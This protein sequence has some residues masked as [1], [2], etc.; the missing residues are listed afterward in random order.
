VRTL[1]VVGIGSGDPRQLTGQA[2]D[3]LARAD[4]VLVLE[5]EKGDDGDALAAFRRALLG[6]GMAGDHRVVVR[7]DPERDR[8]AG[9]YLGSVAAWHEARVDVY[10]QVLREELAEGEVAA[11]LVWGDPSLYDST[12]RIVDRLHERDTV[13]FEHEVVPGI[14]SVQALCAAHR[15]PLNRVGGSV[16]VTT[17]R[18]LAEGK[19]EGVDDVVVL[20]DGSCAFQEVDAERAHIWWG[21]YLGMPEQV[22]ISGPLAECRDQIVERRAA[23]RAEHGW[24]FDAYLIRWERDQPS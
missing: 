6:E 14:S 22:L 9:D 18:R 24:I 11:V 8:A 17:G 1:L 13:A 15:I 3:A 5:K 16:L 7:S 12:L 2:V 4:V 21:A 20:L 19:P 10:E 23:L